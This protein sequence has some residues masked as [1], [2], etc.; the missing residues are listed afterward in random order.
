ML[1]CILFFSEVAGCKNV[2]KTPV[3]MHKQSFFDRSNAE[4][5]PDPNM[6]QFY[7]C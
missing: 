6:L 4:T 7:I 1:I 2:H 5:L 3:K